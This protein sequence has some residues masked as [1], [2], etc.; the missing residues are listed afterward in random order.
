MRKIDAAIMLTE[1]IRDVSVLDCNVIVCDA[2][3][4]ILQFVQANTFQA[5]I[6][7]GDT[8]TGG[9]IKE[10]LA[11][12]QITKGIIPERVYGV[13]LKAIIY[14][15]VEADGNLSG[16]LGTATSLRMQEVLHQSAESVA[17]TSQQ[18]AASTEELALSAGLL[19]SNLALAKASGD[20]VLGEIGKTNEILRFVSDVANN[21]NLL[22][23]NAA[24]E[25]A[26]AGE[27]GRGFA[28][29][30]DEIR[31]MAVNSAQSVREIR[32]ILDRMQTETR[33]A[34]QAIV[35]TSELGERQLV[36]TEQIKV[37]MQ[38]L[39]TSASEIERIAEVV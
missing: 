39:A 16:V 3:A 5:D 21:S 11:K 20:S 35:A 31:K 14:P 9:V 37:T 34:V 6:K 12:R 36:A 26:R 10:C 24:I 23:L 38:E 1:M 15:I 4:K 30:A 22:G 8:A 7:V 25:A 19:A 28:V 2:E 29:V 18:M 17:A 13:T 32:G 27:K 33:N